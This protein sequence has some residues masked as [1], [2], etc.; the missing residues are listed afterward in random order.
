MCPLFRSILSYHAKGNT[1]TLF[2]RIQKTYS[3]TWSTQKQSQKQWKLQKLISLYRVS[4]QALW[5]SI[6]SVC[7]GREV[8]W[9]QAE[10]RRRWGLLADSC[11]GWLDRA[12]MQERHQSSLGRI[13]L[14]RRRQGHTSHRPNPDTSWLLK[15]PTN[16]AYWCSGVQ[17]ARHR[18]SVLIRFITNQRITSSWRSHASSLWDAGNTGV[19]LDYTGC[20]G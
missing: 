19:S 10:W 12:L 11:Y 4:L 15:L 20:G 14:N 2:T 1:Y 18:P 3:I 13:P 9:W 5:E 17:A 6:T 7:R 8:K 16:R